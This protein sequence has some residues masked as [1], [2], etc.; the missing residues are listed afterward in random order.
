MRNLT[1][2]F[3]SKNYFSPFTADNKN[4]TLMSAKVTLGDN[5]KASLGVGSEWS[6]KEGVHKVKPALEAKVDF[7]IGEYLSTQARFRE[8]GGAEQ[9]RVAFTGKYK[10]NKHNSVYATTHFTTKKDKEWENSTGGWIGYSYKFNNGISIS[11]ELEQS[12]PLKKS[13]P[14]VGHSIG[15]FND[16]NKTFNL[17]VSV[18]F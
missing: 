14:S 18:P 1:G 10:I 9:Y 4:L 12:I 16:S 15:S 17:N 6:I 5:V 2:E 13:A 11:A 7:S 3:S 8:I